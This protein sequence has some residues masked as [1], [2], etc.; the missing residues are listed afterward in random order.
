MFFRL[1]VCTCLLALCWAS[2]GRAAATPV[3]QRDDRSAEVFVRV[4][5]EHRNPAFETVEKPLFPNHE[6]V[7]L[8]ASGRFTGDLCPDLLARDR[9][10]GATLLRYGGH[11]NA[12]IPWQGVP[13]SADGSATRDIDL[14]S[15]GFTDLVMR[16]PQTKNR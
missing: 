8:L 13:D 3:D 7:E 1:S 5:R 16:D 11:G 6:D 12:V 2:A 10:S 9:T 15:D 14:D 4:L